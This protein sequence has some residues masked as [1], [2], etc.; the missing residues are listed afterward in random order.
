MNKLQK[1]AWVNLAFVTVCVIVAGIGFASL[2]SHN[3]KGMDY[4]FIG[5]VAGSITMLVVGLGL[6][7]K[8]IEAKFDEREKMV[9]RKA[10]IGAACTLVIYLWI[11]CTVPFF[12]IGGKGVITVSF[13]PAI[14]FSGLFVAQ[15]THSGIILVMCLWEEE[16]G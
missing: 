1:S 10:F 7:K 4:I 3:A 9:N 12:L 14:F 6:R 8:G 13:L 15:I 2:T 5:L 11:V 16:N